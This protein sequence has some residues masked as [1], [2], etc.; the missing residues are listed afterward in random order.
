M[1][2]FVLKADAQDYTVHSPDGKTVVRVSVKDGVRYTVE[3]N[4]KVIL[5]PAAIG[6]TTSL[7]G[8]GPLKVTA[9]KKTKADQW[10]RPVV[11]QKNAVI[12]DQYEQLHIRF[13]NRLALEWRAYNNGVA[14]RWISEANGTFEVLAEQ[15]DF[16]FRPN[17]PAWYPV[18]D[19]F[20]S[21]NE[22]LYKQMRVDSIIERKAL[23]SL[24]ALFNAGGVKVLITESG[25]LDYAGMWLKGDSTGM[26]KGIF[27]QYPTKTELVHDRFEVVRKRADYIASLQGAVQFPWRIM[28]LAEEDKD[29]LV[30]ELVYQLATPSTG[31]FSWVKP[32]KAIWDWWND[33]NIYGV[34]FRAGINTA[35]YKYY[36]DFAAKYGLEYVV[37][38]EGWSDTRNLARISKDM[39]MDGLARYAAEKKVGLVLWVNWEAIS[40]PEQL[41]SAMAQFSSWGVKAIKVDFMQ[42]DDQPML[43]YYLR[44][45]R[46]AAEHKMLV[47][48]HG[49]HK[50]AGLQRTYPNVITFEGVYGLEQS[51]GDESRSIDAGHNVTFPFIRMAAGPADY[52]P[53]AM[54]NAQKDQWAPH[55]N[56]PMS[57]GTRCHQLA[58]YV[59]YESPLQMLADNPTH[60]YREP[61]C[62]AFL[63]AVPSVWDSTIVLQAEIG[64]Y[65]LTARKAADG[66]W[67][68]GGMT[69]GE[70]RTLTMDCTFLPA[71]KYKMQVWK[72]GI[73]ADRNAQ[74]FKMEETVIDHT[75]RL[76]VVMQRGGGW[77]ARITPMQ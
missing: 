77:A 25:L 26:I 75:T 46:A 73:N 27:P 29:L 12:R 38:D 28:M 74:D 10:L 54:L 41:Q 24:P 49:A 16:A 76:P 47:D 15:A 13:K 51:K 11:R 52:T 6:L 31:D 35:T 8:N 18:E 22:R 3:R 62:M 56:R 2:T 43:Q 70:G 58:M 20:F 4:G 1:M 53:G 61:E 7:T 55:W 5:Q 59:V 40:K 36:I 39:D 34:D 48:F 21:H 64:R 63:A 42:R 19:E 67:Y 57:I 33:N 72:D 17:D 23:A 65:I 14:W 37:L 68:V 69:N 60:Y 9:A 32:G 44:V 30:N 66:S 71:G 50:P 45:S